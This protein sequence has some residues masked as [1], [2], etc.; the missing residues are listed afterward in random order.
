M[1]EEFSVMWPRH[2][3]MYITQSCWLN[4]NFM[5]FKKQAPTGSDNTL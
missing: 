1:F 2:L 5:T 4:Y 3:S